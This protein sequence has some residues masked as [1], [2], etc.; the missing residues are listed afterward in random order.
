MKIDVWKYIKT[1]LMGQL[2]EFCDDHK[3]AHSLRQLFRDIFL[4]SCNKLA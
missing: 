2:V 3:R 1:I 4:V